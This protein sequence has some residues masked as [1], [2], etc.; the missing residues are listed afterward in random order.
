MPDEDR[1]DIGL[2]AK[3]DL[4][5]A[6]SGHEF[7]DALIIKLLVAVRD[8]CQRF[9]TGVRIV[10]RNGSVKGE[11]GAADRQVELPYG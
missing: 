6:C 4:H 10:G 11:V 9:A 7:D 8:L 3:I 2:F 1:I 5:P